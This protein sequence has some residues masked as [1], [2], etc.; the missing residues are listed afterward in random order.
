MML[1]GFRP[2]ILPLARK[3]TQGIKHNPQNSSIQFSG[4]RHSAI[5]PIP[6]PYL[7]KPESERQAPRANGHYQVEHSGLNTSRGVDNDKGNLKVTLTKKVG[8]LTASGDIFVYETNVKG[9]IEAGGGITTQRT[10]VVGSLKSGGAVHATESTT[11]KKIQ[12]L[13][14]VDIWALILKKGIH[15]TEGNINFNSSN[16]GGLLKADSGNVL[17][18]HA[19][20]IGGIEAG[21]TA[22]I[23]HTSEVKGDIRAAHKVTLRAK[24]TDPTVVHNIIMT[25]DRAVVDLSANTK[26]KGEIHFEK[27]GGVVLLQPGAMFDQSKTNGKIIWDDPEPAYQAAET[28]SHISP[29]RQSPFQL[30][31]KKTLDSKKEGDHS[32][33]REDGPSA[34]T[35][36]SYENID[37]PENNA[38]FL[39]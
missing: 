8:P 28:Q 22:T 11:I 3:Q 30:D 29:Q 32:T 13:K 15:S 26:V 33:Q 39:K 31:D 24:K 20:Y 5:E 37:K 10:E 7:E 16:A 19:D 2:T 17:V 1:T 27:A 18:E 25:G 23:K 38:H 12:A 36:P 9:N 14:N 4:N 34:Q 21:D 35:A 6:D